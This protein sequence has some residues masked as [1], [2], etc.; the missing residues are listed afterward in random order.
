MVL[1]DDFN[2][3]EIWYSGMTVL[4]L[5]LFVE[6]DL[7][8]LP[9]ATTVIIPDSFSIPKSLQ[10]GISC[11]IDKEKSK[12]KSIQCGITSCCWEVRFLC[13]FNYSL[14]N[15]LTCSIGHC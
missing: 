8:K 4:L 13:T 2:D 9:K 10:Q 11:G 3:R 12:H 14:I 1:S 15:I 7:Y 6:V 5:Y